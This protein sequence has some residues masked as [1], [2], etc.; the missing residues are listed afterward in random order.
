M[1]VLLRVD[2]FPGTKPEEFW[3]H[4]FDN[5]KRFDDVIARHHINRYILG[6]IP[7]YTTEKHIDWLGS[8]PRIEVAM[9]GIEH[10]ERFP[11]EF[12]DHDTIDDIYKKLLSAKEPLKRC[13]SYNDV[14]TYIPPHNVFDKKTIVALQAA[15][16][17]AILGGP[18]SDELVREQIKQVT[19]MSF[20]YSSSPHYYGRSDEMI[21]RDRSPEF[22]LR[23]NENFSPFRGPTKILTLHWTW[24]WNIG[25]LHLD[26]FLTKIAPILHEEIVQLD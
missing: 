15:G 13:N 10:D 9:H 2:D 19:T 26:Q 1:S 11:N 3:K 20:V 18:G 4:N 14:R 7:K 22:L 25:L 8:N 24:E 23:D 16:F 6:V 12:R 21:S 5:F 17:D